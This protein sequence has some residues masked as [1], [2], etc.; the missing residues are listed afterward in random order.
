MER[1]LVADD[2]RG[3]RDILG[4]HLTREGYEFVLA[5][6]GEEAVKAHE[7]APFDLVLT[8]L[9]LPQLDGIG[10]CKAVKA[11]QPD[12]AVIMMTAY[13]TDES[14]KEAG[15]AGAD[16]YIVKAFS[17]VEEQVIMPIRCA[18]ARR[19]WLPKPLRGR[20]PKMKV[21]GNGIIGA[22]GTIQR[23]LETVRK[24]ADNPSTVLI[25]GE[26]GTGKELIA[27]AIHD[28][29]RRREQPF[30]TVNCSAL[31]ESLLE[32]ELFGHM[33]GSFTGAIAN[34]VGLFEVADT[35]TLLL[36]EIGEV[37]TAIQV[38]LLRV[39]QDKEFRRIGGTKDLKVDVRVIA[40]SNRD[41]GQA[42]HQGGFREDLYYR[43]SVIPIHLPPLRERRED[44]PLLVEH[45]MNGLNQSLGTRVRSVSPEAVAHLSAQPWRG[46]VRELENVIERVVA[47]TTR[48]QITPSDMQDCLGLTASIGIP[49][50]PP[51]PAGGLDL[52]EA[53]QRLEKDLLIRAMEK[54]RWDQREAALL[55]RMNP[56]S[57]R[58][59][60][61]KYRIKQGV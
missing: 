51:L 43:L 25:L 12:T 16:G 7:A 52:D 34:K 3:L 40:A 26:S 36:D 19:P 10:V 9:K 8:Y 28:A 31:P 44:I 14:S 23:I 33:K 41:L 27:R 39:L 2:E 55:L 47:L 48:D 58:Y 13:A 53:I 46:N 60:L 22:S 1:V 21:N 59:R 35:G 45:F 32:S 11:I 49:A 57:L 20:G 29:S 4:L 61:G 56:R 38:K 5:A 50:E 54:T 30:V 15:R 17:N 24:V 37:S 6:T 42:I 18:L